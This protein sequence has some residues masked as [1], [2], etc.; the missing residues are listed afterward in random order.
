ME[1]DVEA[2]NTKLEREQRSLTELANAAAQAEAAVASQKEALATAKGS[3]AEA[4]AVAN[5]SWQTLAEQQSL[6][7]SRDATL[8]STKEEKLALETAMND[9]F[10]TP[11]EAA[12]GPNFKELEPFLHKLE[13]DSTLLTTL[14]SVCA[15]TKDDRSTFDGAVLAELDKAMSSKLAALSAVVETE[16]PAAIERETTTKE[17]EVQCI[18]KKKAQTDLEADLVAAQNLLCEREATFQKA[19]EAVDNMNLQIE[20]CAGSRE[21]AQ[22]ILKAYEN[23][24]LANFLSCKSKSTV[25]TEAVSAGA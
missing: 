13:I 8:V 3:L 2:E 5:G 25:P 16:T 17:L 22:S 20:A 21:K 11:M 24:V 14:P 19:K 23:G 10:K 15:K 9:H 1:S 18:S 6:R 12:A 4:A 7:Q